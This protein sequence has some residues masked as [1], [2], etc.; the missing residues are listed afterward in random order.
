M[1]K[2]IESAFNT[3]LD[4]LPEI[5]SPKK[6]LDFKTKFVWTAL[7][8]SIYFVL[9][10]VPLYGLSPTFKSQF[11]TLA[12][13]LA[14]NTGSLITLGIGPIVTGSIIIQLLMGADI[15]KIDTNSREGK[16]KYQS[17]QK[18]FSIAFILFE[19]IIYV[20]SGALP[21]ACVDSLNCPA[22]MNLFTNNML[23]AVQLIIGGFILMALDELMSKWGFMSGISLFIAAGVA[24]RIFISL[25]SPRAD[26]YSAFGFKVGQVFKIFGLIQTGYPADAAMALI[27]V[28]ATIAVFA[29]SIYL[30]SIKVEIPL[31]FGRVRG[32]GIRWPLSFIYTS[33]I[34]VILV[35]AFIA[36]LQFAGVMFDNMGFPLLGHFETIN[37]QQTAVSGLVKYVRAPNI[38]DMIVAPNME[39]LYSLLTYTAFMLI[40]AVIFSV[41]WINV[42]GQDAKTVAEQITSSGLFIPGFRSDPRIIERILKRYIMPLTIMG[43]LSVGIIAVIADIFGAFGHGT[44]I[45]LTVMIVY[46]LYE[47]MKQHDPM[48]M[49][50]AVRKFMR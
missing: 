20:Y 10:M 26:P 41:L 18:L 12:V 13:L 16:R 15:I 23:I 35:S 49:P 29:V 39:Q 40:G 30:Q 7:G 37:G 45:L 14:A 42:G 50:E 3:L 36:S 4:Y 21:A 24:R 32:F 46:K 6:K 22:G 34:P 48:E 8:I 33:N 28:V 17:I 47:A 1:N 44:G 25:F 38:R 11:E 31:S 43:G 27:P 2:K 5:N 9:S 19:N